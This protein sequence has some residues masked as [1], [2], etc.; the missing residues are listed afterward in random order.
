[1]AHLAPPWA[2]MAPIVTHAIQK[3][4]AGKA[5]CQ[6]YHWAMLAIPENTMNTPPATRGNS[7]MRSTMWVRRLAGG[8]ARKRGHTTQS[9][10]RS[11]GREAIPVATCTP[12]VRRYRPA[13]RA[14]TGNHDSGCWWRWE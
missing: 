9:L 12:W 10:A 6:G 1:M 2:T 3:W 7:P 5:K 11:T 8:K 13:G 14:G 4:A